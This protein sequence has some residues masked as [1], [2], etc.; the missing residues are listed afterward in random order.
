MKKIVIILFSLT[1]TVS[2]SQVQ[3]GT[4]LAVN[5][6]NISISESEQTDFI[7]SDAKS[8]I[9]IRLGFTADI[10][11]SYFTSLN[12]GILYSVKGFAS[13]RD[14]NGQMLNKHDLVSNYL[15]IPLSMSYKILNSLSLN[16]GPYLGILI[17]KT[18]T[19]LEEESE[20]RFTEDFVVDLG[21]S[22][23][24]RFIITNDLSLNAGYEIELIDLT[25]DYYSF[26]NTNI[27]FGMTYL[28]VKK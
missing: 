13:E 15:E 12:T 3:L 25:E 19:L 6:S 11:L 7:Y 14:Y 10:P 2:F 5:I 17:G 9:G 4:L 22:V 23:A 20:F 18:L 16:A 24:T 21:F 27:F 28:F 1:S 26:K 8:K